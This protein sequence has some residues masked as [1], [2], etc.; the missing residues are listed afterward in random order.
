MLKNIIIISCNYVSKNSKHVTINE[1]KLNLFVENIKDIKMNHWLSSSPFGL[2]NLSVETIINFLLIYES[3]NFSFWGEPKWTID[4]NIGKLDGSIA[5]LYVLLQYVKESKSTDFS[6]MSK[7]EFLKILKGNIK[8]PLFEERFKIIKEVSAIVNDK[9]QGN[10]YQYIKDITS[11]IELFE[12]IIANFPS[13]KDERLYNKQTIY[14]YKLAQLLTS[15]I[16]HIRE[17]KEKIKVNYTHLVGCADYKIP[18]ILRK[19]GILNYDNKLAKI[20]DN[21]IEIPINSIYEVEIRA[22]MIT[23]INMINKKLNYKYCRIDIND[24]IYMQKNNKNFKMK[25]YHLTRCTNY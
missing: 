3:I 12:T 23:V 25:P 21:H 16:L 22:N 7:K 5:L 11:D 10:F 20:V 15:D 17:Q 9:M 18:Q 14:F 2:L 4:T 8:I 6:S 13:F 19:F 1:E 24:F